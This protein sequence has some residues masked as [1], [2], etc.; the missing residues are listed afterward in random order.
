M[1]ISKIWDLVIAG[2]GPAALTAGLYAARENLQVLVVEKQTFGG[3]VATI[4]RIDNFP[5]TMVGTSG[6]V[7]AGNLIEQ[8]KS[9]GVQMDYGEVSAIARHEDGFALTVDGDEVLARSVL[10]ATGLE[11]RKLGVAGEKLQ[12]VHYCATCDGAFYN[13]KRVIVVG[14]GN[15][16]LQEAFYLAKIVGHITIISAGEL[17]ASHALR[18][19]LSR[20]KEIEVLE[21]TVIEEVV[22]LDGKVNGVRIGDDMIEADG[23]FVFIG[24]APSVGF[25]QDLEVRVDEKGFI[26]TDAEMMTNVA[27]VFAAGDV[28]S[29]SVKQ[30][31]TAAGEGA[32]AAVAI[33]KYLS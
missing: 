31:I 22:G 25:L 8:A 1:A 28:R 19:E 9:F 3:K 12:G 17:T 30:A 26:E 6:E 7:L 18:E 10:V 4:S 20:H 14:G 33:G 16:A 11:N 15:S 27:G 29:G 23:V 5:G 21:N 24:H 13:G 32:V 2:A